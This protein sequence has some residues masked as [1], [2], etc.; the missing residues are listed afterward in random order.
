MAVTDSTKLEVWKTPEVG[1]SC[2]KSNNPVATGTKRNPKC[3]KFAHD[4][5]QWNTVQ[6]GIC[7][8]A[9]INRQTNVGIQ[10]CQISSNQNAAHDRAFTGPRKNKYLVILEN[11]SK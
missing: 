11:Q 1:N 5:K 3:S 10:E 4:R 7:L 9:K 2:K 6:R 8:W